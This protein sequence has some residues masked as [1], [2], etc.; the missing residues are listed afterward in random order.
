MTDEYIKPL[1][2]CMILIIPAKMNMD[3]KLTA[4]KS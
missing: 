3:N 4:I 1:N 2:V